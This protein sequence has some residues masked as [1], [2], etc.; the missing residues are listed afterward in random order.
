MKRALLAALVLAV[1]LLGGF[2]C[3][4][5]TQ[6]VWHEGDICTYSLD[7][8]NSTCGDS[9]TLLSCGADDLV[10][11]T[12]CSVLCGGSG[13][14]GPDPTG[15]DLNAC[16]CDSWTPGAS[17][18]YLTQYDD[19]TCFGDIL[20]YCASTNVVGSISCYDQCQQWYGADATGTCGIQAETGYNGCVCDVPA[21]CSYDFYCY[22]AL[23][24]VSCVD[25]SDVW[26]DCN[27]Q[28]IAAGSTKGV[29]DPNLGC[30]C[31]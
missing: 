17:C 22:D 30:Q 14:C 21:G 20:T 19:S 31:S 8:D 12:S 4:V 15:Y 16:I 9:D 2:E 3:N 1:P 10:Y 13:H 26:T 29:C 11:A 6:P 28:C 27:D 7:Y 5:V 23:W 25:G 24:M 18:D